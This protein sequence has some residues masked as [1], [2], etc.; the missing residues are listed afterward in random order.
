MPGDGR[1]P[2]TKTLLPLAHV[3]TPSDAHFNAT[4]L[5]CCLFLF[6]YCSFNWNNN[7]NLLQSASMPCRPMVVHGMMLS[8]Y[9]LNLRLGSVLSLAGWFFRAKLKRKD[10]S[11]KPCDIPQ[12]PMW[13][14]RKFVPRAE[15]PA[16]SI[17]LLDKCWHLNS[18]FRLCFL[19]CLKSHYFLV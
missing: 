2:P 18:Y 16:V 5:K 12:S 9:E 8:A 15:I 6:S 14:V 3:N 7:W 1:N 17:K 4:A 10:K 13:M 19:R 11:T